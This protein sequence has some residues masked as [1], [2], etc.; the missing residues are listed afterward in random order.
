MLAPAAFL[1]RVLERV[2]TVR[3]VLGIGISLKFRY[4]ADETLTFYRNSP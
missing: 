3:A 2:T 1:G 4:F